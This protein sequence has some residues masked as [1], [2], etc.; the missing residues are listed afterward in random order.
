MY[1]FKLISLKEYTIRAVIKVSLSS[2]F[3]SSFIPFFI[4]KNPNLYNFLSFVLIGIFVSGIVTAPFAYL[5]GYRSFLA[6]ANDIIKYM[7]FISEKNLT[8]NIDLRNLGYLKPVGQHLNET[9]YFLNNQI[10]T[11]QTVSDNI[12]SKNKESSKSFENMINESSNINSL[13]QDNK[14]NLNTIISEFEKTTQSMKHLKSDSSVIINKIN[15]NLSERSSIH[16]FLLDNEK[17]LEIAEKSVVEFI[18]DFPDLE[19][20]ILEFNKKFDHIISITNLINNISNQTNLL[21]LNASIEAARA[22]EHGRGFMVVAEEIKKLAEQANKSAQFINV[23]INEIKEDSD[24]INKMI[25][26]EKEKSNI[27][28]ESFL[29]IKNN[30]NLFLNFIENNNTQDLETLKDF[31]IINKNISDVTLY[32][33]NSM[34]SILNYQEINKDVLNSVEAINLDIHRYNK[35]ILFFTDIFQELNEI[36][37]DFKTKNVLK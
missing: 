4:Y 22:G 13:I 6:P 35:N 20:I 14:N 21:A 28:Y 26:K 3:V 30:T 25:L 34:K 8:H 1:K 29:T 32:I 2:G 33:D 16:H 17:Q 7:K 23:S 24:Y 12:Y 19:R 18:N 11:I 9:I 31:D 15:D 37:K 10:Q 27:A 5:V 36:T